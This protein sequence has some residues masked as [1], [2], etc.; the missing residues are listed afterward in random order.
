[1]NKLRFVCP[2][3]DS[4]RTQLEEAR[5]NKIFPDRVKMRFNSILLSDRK[6]TIKEI[7][8]IYQMD[9]DT[10]SIW[11]KNW[12]QDGIMGLFDK[13]KV[14]RKPTLTEEELEIL[15]ELIRENPR[16]SKIVAAKLTERTGK[17]LSHWSV[18]RWAK[19]F[20]LKW[21]RARKSLKSKRNEEDFEKA[22]QD[23]A[24]FEKEQEKGE[25]DVVYF[26]GSGFNLTP[27][28]PYAWQPIGKDNTIEIPSARSKGINVL[29]FLSK[30]NEL[31]PYVFENSI[32]GAVVAACFNN[33]AG[34]ISKPTVVMLDNAP[35]HTGKIFSD[36]IE[37]WQEKGLFPYFISAYSPELNIIEIL[38]KKIKYEWLSFF[39][40]EN[41][42]KLKKELETILKEC[43]VKYLI[44]FT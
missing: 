27:C 35:M 24:A 5:K 1:M 32:T 20:N 39:A 40:Y 28:V 42:E 13:P 33:F 7:S 31:T 25:I 26:D 15:K 23:I 14:N 4:Q 11:I 34:R 38:W 21:K 9:R 22:E 2:L 19:K 43:G 37:K 6:F 17:S 12:E 3:T 44:D 18:R 29:A 16:S 10:V 8:N 30:H 41:L 36:N